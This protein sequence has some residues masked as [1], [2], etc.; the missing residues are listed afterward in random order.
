[1]AASEPLPSSEPGASAAA[2]RRQA[3]E[4]EARALASTVRLRIIR[5][6]LDEE[7]TNKEIAQRL[8]R[9]PASVFHHVGRLVDMRQ[10]G[11]Q[12]TAAEPVAD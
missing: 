3:T 7:L 8:D 6:C 2:G 10:P 11:S 5:L 1:M 4:A 12:A 9:D